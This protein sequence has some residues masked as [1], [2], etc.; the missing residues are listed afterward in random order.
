MKFILLACILTILILF[1]AS[2]LHNP[3]L[4][5]GSTNKL[6]KNIPGCSVVKYEEVLLP[7]P[8]NDNHFI[9]SA[10]IPHWDPTCK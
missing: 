5:V 8:A 2:Q 3:K 6:G 10:I 9:I 1:K 7:L 4:S